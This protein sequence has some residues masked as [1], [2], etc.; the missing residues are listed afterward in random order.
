MNWYLILDFDSTIITKES[1][2]FLSEIALENEKN[3]DFLLSKIIELT[4]KG[5]DGI[6]SFQ[7]SINERLK[8]KH[9]TKDHIKILNRKLKDHITPTFQS[10]MRWLKK[11]SRRIY[12]ISGGFK[13]MIIPITDKLNISREHIFANDFVFNKD[14]IVMGLDKNNPLSRSGGKVKKA[15]ELNLDG[16][17]FMVGDGSTDAEMKNLGGKVN[18]IAFVENVYREKVVSQADYTAKTFKDVINFIQSS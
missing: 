1:L 16:Q 9:I 15:E 12:I 18:F 3:K 8:S 14:G 5:M 13:E 7:D 11:Y 17:I 6:I 2:D 10:N 4:E